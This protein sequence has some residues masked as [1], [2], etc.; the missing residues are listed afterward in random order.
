MLTNSSDAVVILLAAGAIGAIFSSTSPDMG[1]EGILDRYTQLRPKVFVCE[2]EVVYGGRRIDL[3]GRFAEVNRRLRHAVPEMQASLVVRGP[4]F[5]GPNMYVCPP[6]GK[7]WTT[8]NA[9]IV[10]AFTPMTFY[11]GFL[12][13]LNVTTSNFPLNTQYMSC[14]RRWR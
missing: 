2:T 5:E 3:R 6:C 7:R 13:P 10:V 12:L 9:I 14:T 4:L 11:D 1:L 8:T